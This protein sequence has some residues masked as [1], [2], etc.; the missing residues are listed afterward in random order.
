VT[1]RKLSGIALASGFVCVGLAVIVL[2]LADGPRRWYS[3]LFFA[4]WAAVMLV[5]AWHWRRAADG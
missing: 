1:R 4:L 2:V 5:S 3:G